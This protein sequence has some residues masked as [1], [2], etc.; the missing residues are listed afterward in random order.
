MAEN[1]PWLSIDV[2][3]RS[4]TVGQRSAMILGCDA[5]G[6]IAKTFCIPGHPKGEGWLAA[7]GHVDGLHEWEPILWV[8]LPERFQDRDGL[9]PELR[10]VLENAPVQHCTN[11]DGLGEWDEG[12][13][14]ARHSAQ[15][16]PEYLRVICP[17]CG[18][19]GVEDAV[20]AAIKRRKEAA[21]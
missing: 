15:E 17:E 21:T 20:A 10:A 14:P 12:P 1:T 19:T 5:Q 6:M 18:G 3:D 11:C 9:T 16:E 2:A 8:P 7:T 13:L 4:P